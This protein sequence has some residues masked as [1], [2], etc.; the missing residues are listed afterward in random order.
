[1]VPFV[2]HFRFCTQAFSLPQDLFTFQITQHTL[3]GQ[4][5]IVKVIPGSYAASDSA[6]SLML[7]GKARIHF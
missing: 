4:A 5:F 6:A 2:K 7:V 1:M 3:V